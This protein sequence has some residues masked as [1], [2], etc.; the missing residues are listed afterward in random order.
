MRKGFKIT[1][2]EESKKEQ[3]GLRRSPASIS[4]T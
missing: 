3:R 2:K 1:K 4:L